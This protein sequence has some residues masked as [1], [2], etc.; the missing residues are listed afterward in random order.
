MQ[1]WEEVYFKYY[2]HLENKCVEATL[3]N[4]QK[5]RVNCY[6]EKNKAGKDNI[7]IRCLDTPD[8]PHLCCNVPYLAKLKDRQQE[9]RENLYPLMIK[10]YEEYKNRT[11]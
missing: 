10:K 6:F 4:P 2:S 7:T 11:N 9:M 3:Q 1:D 8:Y 5:G